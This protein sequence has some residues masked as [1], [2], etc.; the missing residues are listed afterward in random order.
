MARPREF[1]ETQAL[2][3]AID[4]FWAMGYGGAGTRDLAARMGLTTASFYNAFGDKRGL[5]LKAL[6]LYLKETLHQRIARLD[7]LAPRDAVAGF[8]ADVI[9][10]SLADPA[11]RGCMLVNIT[12][13][14]AAVEVREEIS[15]AFAQ[16]HAFFRRHI[17]A[18]QDDGSIAASQP[19]DDLARLFQGLVLGIRVMAR[20]APERAVLEGMA[21]PALALL[22]PIH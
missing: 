5:F 15:A 14:A 20:T 22:D 6:D 1:D 11:Y 3:A 13:D 19:A 2:K 4:G 10:R 7:G 21:R 12:L 16:I 8:M 18:G 9:D 17:Q